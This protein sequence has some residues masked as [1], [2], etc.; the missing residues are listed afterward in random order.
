MKEVI[1]PNTLIKGTNKKYNRIMVVDNL[2]MKI[3][4]TCYQLYEII[5][6]GIIRK[7]L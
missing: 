4:S 3:L 1:I 2:G 6:Q 7:Y 5:F